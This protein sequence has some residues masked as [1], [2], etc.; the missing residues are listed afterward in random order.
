M[1]LGLQGGFKEIEVYF[2][3]FK[4]LFGFGFGDLLWG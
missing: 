2:P 4:S 3:T 1:V